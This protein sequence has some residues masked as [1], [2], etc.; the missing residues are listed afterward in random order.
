MLRPILDQDI[1]AMHIDMASTYEVCKLSDLT[2][3]CVQLDLNDC[4]L[5]KLR[6][7]VGAESSCIDL[8]VGTSCPCADPACQDNEER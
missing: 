5:E 1:Q 3:K 8:A 7:A 4:R 6:R 2:K